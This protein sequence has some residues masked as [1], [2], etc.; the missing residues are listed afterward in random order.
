VEILGRETPR[1]SIMLIVNRKQIFTRVVFV[2]IFIA[3]MFG[4]IPVQAKPGESYETASTIDY[5]NPDG[6]L[7]LKDGISGSLNLQG[8]DIQ[9]DPE[10]GPI[11]R[12]N[13]V[14]AATISPGQWDSLGS[15]GA[16]N[17]GVTAITING[18]DVYVA[19][20]FTNAGGIAEADHVAKWDGTKWS[21]LGG[22]D[23][24]DG[25]ISGQVY[26]IAT[27]GTDIY[28]G[29]DFESIN[30]HGNIINYGAVAKWDGMN[31]SAV[32]NL[33]IGNFGL[34]GHIVRT[35]VVSG[36]NIYIGGS[37]YDL[38]SNGV[39][40]ADGDGLIKWDG[41][42]WSVVGD[43]GNVNGIN[44]MAVIGTDIYVGGDFI[45]AGSI[46]EADYVV[47]WDGTNW[48]ALGNNGAGNGALN[49]NVHAIAASG[50]DLYVGG[51]FSDAGG[52]PEADVIAK[53]DGTNWSALGDNGAGNG[54]LDPSYMSVR[55]I[56]VDGT[57]VYVGGAIWHLN[58]NGVVLNTVTSIAKWDGVNWSGLGSDGAGGSAINDYVLAIA[59]IG[60]TVYA[61][62]N[63]HNVN[64]KGVVLTEVDNFAKWDGVDW[65]GVGK[66]NGSIFGDV[67][68]IAVV[69]TDVYVGGCFEDVNNDP[70]SNY[71]VKWDG[72][73]WSNLRTS[74]L[75]PSPI[76]NCIYTL[77]TDGTNLYVGGAFQ[78]ANSIPSA[79]YIAKWDGTNWSALGSNGAGDGS[80]TAPWGGVLTIAMAG[81]DVYIGGNF[82]DVNNNGTTLT[83]ADYIAKWDGTNWSAL[84]GDGTGDG[85]LTTIEQSDEYHGSVGYVNAIAVDGSDLYAG[86]YF[87][88]VRNGSSTL[89][90]GDYIVK[91]DGTNWS[92]LGSNGTNDGAIT[93][94]VKA[95]AVRG[96]EVY[97]GGDFINAGGIPEADYIAKW[98]GVNWS[99]LGDDGAGDGAIKRLLP[100]FSP[101]NTIGVDGL[102]IYVG[103]HFIDIN[104][105]GSVI[106]SADY[107]ARW[108]GT[109]WSALSTNGAGGG[110][111]N[112]YVNSIYLHGTDMYVG[113]SF[114]DVNSNGE[115]LPSADSIA[116]YGY[117]T[118]EPTFGDVP[119][120]HPY[121]DYIEILYANG[122]TGGCSTS[123]LLFCPDMVM[124]R[125]QSAVFMLRGNFGSGYTPVTPTHFFKDNW[126]RAG[127]AEGWAES[128]YLE[129]LT[130]GCV[131]NPLKFCPYEKLTNE[132]AAVF[133]LRLKYGT[134]YMPPPATGTVFADMTNPGYWAIS[135]AE[136]AYLDGLIPSCGTDIATGKPKF[137]P[138]DQVDRGFGAFI[139]VT[140]KNLTMP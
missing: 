40:L 87:Y 133:G 92:A 11:F 123:P 57:N 80:I 1:E 2:Y 50:T 42:H 35:I 121:F 127:W 30:N 91:W 32:G 12:N 96:I 113:G 3:G 85:S 24:G 76:N 45:N 29:G 8:W 49:K 48:S 136:Q 90:S 22:N 137:C 116:L 56:F 44:A 129:G 25:A 52:V 71:L 37:F 31:W 34:N 19:G 111:L 13:N 117:A 114:M 125:A 61:G 60:N 99:G 94:A 65:S 104:N 4:A 132:Q 66:G 140:A 120:S 67:N 54:A 128:M 138:R 21:A 124:D 26:A 107:I 105:H 39:V 9:L 106:S 15:S 103:G 59:L 23:M 47:K 139:I 130:A 86:G 53:W 89:A 77:A 81:M 122:Y 135:W 74:N 73:N 41:T 14:Y 109:N 63:F 36:A 17:G 27:S 100:Y 38:Y 68:A 102:N 83:A 84:G 62:G 46:P 33:N 5:L 51:L 72:T 10:H 95:I 75:L 131:L 20:H 126:S 82:T 108:D 7:N 101:V 98:N 79:D 58:N 43:S 119:S 16:I 118:V 134:S 18:N 112:S 64:N 110:S 78:N 97:I 88:D 70:Y 69:G 93:D 6:T 55:S 28:V 115:V